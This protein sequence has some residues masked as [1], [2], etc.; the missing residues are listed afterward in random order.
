MAAVKYPE[1]TK[2]FRDWVDGKGPA[3][4]RARAAKV[5]A[6]NQTRELSPSQGGRDALE[7]N[8]VWV[9]LR[10]RALAGLDPQHLI[11]TTG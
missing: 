11:S 3:R 4:A 8:R 6:E 9:S 10:G 2:T 1:R 5:V 7:R